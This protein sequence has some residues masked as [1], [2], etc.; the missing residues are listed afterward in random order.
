VNGPPRAGLIIPSLLTLAGL[1]VL[2]GLG[3]W[4]LERKAW[5]EALIDTIA[6]RLEAAPGAIPPRESWSRLDPAE[7][8]FRRVAFRAAFV[9]DE[10]LVYTTGSALRADVSGPGYWVFAPARLTDGSLVVVDRGFVPDGRQD[11]A[12][13]PQGRLSGPV[14]L[15]GVM[16]WPEPP[17]F[18]TPGPDL[19][20]NTWF[21]RDHL[22]IAAARRWG[23][24][25]PFH[26]AQEAPPAPGGLPRVG[27]VAPNLP[28]NHLA[29][30]LTW[31]GLAAVLAVVFALWVRSRRGAV[32]ARH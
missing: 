18:F 5:K 20:R 11:P 26:V 14:D 4:Q 30:A 2:I 9:D 22:A 3:T 32:T 17:G 16:R 23:A 8:E 27:K 21:V 19:G 7:Q 29:Y 28:N 6:R 15:V 10:A 25:A 24:I 31:Y 1:A 13:R 12:S